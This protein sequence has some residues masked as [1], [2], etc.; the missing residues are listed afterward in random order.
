MS[1][2]ESEVFGV[3]TADWRLGNLGLYDSTVSVYLTIIQQLLT[4]AATGDA[5]TDQVMIRVLSQVWAA[6]RWHAGFP[7]PTHSIWFPTPGAPPPVYPP[8]PLQEELDTMPL[9]VVGA[10]WELIRS[11]EYIMMA[12]TYS[13]QLADAWLD[14]PATLWSPASTEAG[15]YLFQVCKQYLLLFDNLPA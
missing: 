6:L 7:V 5:A 1:M 12:N 15:Q 9:E 3:V 8:T 13:R 10:Q 14:D 4:D 2:T 11:Q